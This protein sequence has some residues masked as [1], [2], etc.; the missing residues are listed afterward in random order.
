MRVVLGF[1]LACDGGKVDS[2]A[3]SESGPDTGCCDCLT[4]SEAFLLYKN[5]WCEWAFSFEEECQ[6]VFE[7]VEQCQ[8]QMAAL[9]PAADEHCQVDSCAADA[10]LDEVSGSECSSEYFAVCEEEFLRCSF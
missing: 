9:A 1:L 8:A 2:S 4:G 7:S 10:C 5:A 3:V 6:G